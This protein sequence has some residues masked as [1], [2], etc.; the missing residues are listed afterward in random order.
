MQT[1]SALAESA[2]PETPAA[3]SAD[4]AFTERGASTDLDQ[5]GYLL[6][7]AVY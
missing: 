1:T 6:G 7:T 2:G 4:A 3:Y 5:L